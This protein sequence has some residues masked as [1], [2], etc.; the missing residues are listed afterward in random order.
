[1][2]ETHG[3]LIQDLASYRKEYLAGD[4]GYNIVAVVMAEKRLQ[5]QDA[6]D[7]VAGY[8]ADIAARFLRV[9]ENVLQRTNGV[10]SWGYR[11][12]TQ[13]AVLIEG[14]GPYH[15]AIGGVMTFD[16]DACL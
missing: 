16:S 2:R 10:P 6:I 4:I 5:L 14:L 12:D 15:S 8:H 13:V 3:G 7:W 9:R 1:M 11:T